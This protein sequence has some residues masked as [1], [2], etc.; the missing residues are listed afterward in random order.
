M[1]QGNLEVTWSDGQSSVSPIEIETGGFNW[2]TGMYLPVEPFVAGKSIVGFYEGG[3]SFGGEG[4]SVIVS[5]SLRLESDG[6]YTMSGIAT[7]SASSN[8]TQARVGGENQEEGRWQLD[9]FIL[10][11][12]KS[13]GTSVQHIAFPFDDEKTPIYPDRIFVGG[14]M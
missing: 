11:L 4:N 12:S 10:S 2:D 8:G 14:T 6:R 1:N 7:V 9:G 3:S 13:D 5:K